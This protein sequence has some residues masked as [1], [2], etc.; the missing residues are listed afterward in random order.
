MAKNDIKPQVHC[1]GEGEACLYMNKVWEGGSL[2]LYEMW[3][4]PKTVTVNPT[5][6]I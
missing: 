6:S 3:Q 1:V 4:G 5:R 2:L